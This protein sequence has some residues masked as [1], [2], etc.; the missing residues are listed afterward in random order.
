MGNTSV[1]ANVPMFGDLIGKPFQY[2]GRGP[3]SFDCYGLVREMSARQG[4]TLPDYVTPNTELGIAMLLS[5]EQRL[6]EEAPRQACSVVAIRVGRLVSHVGFMI[7]EFEMLHVWKHGGGVCVER[8]D[9]WERRIAG[10][11]RFKPCTA[12]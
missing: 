5:N 10:F 8:M 11:Y 6:W 12:Q 2:G 1:V 3:D 4:L 9:E 7:S